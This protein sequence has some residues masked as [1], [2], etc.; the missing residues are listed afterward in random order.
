MLKIIWEPTREKSRA[1]AEWYVNR[2]ASATER[3]K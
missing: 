1:A 2:R 3:S